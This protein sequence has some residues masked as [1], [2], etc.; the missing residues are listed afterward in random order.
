MIDDFVILDSAVK[1]F[2]GNDD[3]FSSSHI[4]YYRSRLWTCLRVKHIAATKWKLVVARS[5]TRTYDNF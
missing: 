4:I 1:I 5:E 2:A 3:S